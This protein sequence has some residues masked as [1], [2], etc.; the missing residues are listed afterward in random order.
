MSCFS[1]FSILWLWS[2]RVYLRLHKMYRNSHVAN[3]FRARR[4]N[5]VAYHEDFTVAPCRCWNGFFC[6]LLLLLLSK[7][8]CH[9]SNNHIRKIPYT[10]KS[11]EGW[12]DIFFTLW[13]DSF[14]EELLVSSVY[15]ELSVQCNVRCNIP[16]FILLLISDVELGNTYMQEDALTSS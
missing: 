16:P 12:V 3:N 9:L 4:H 1:E 2:R 15:R 10:P 8:R 14:V 7:Q 13:G 11:A 5:V 6:K